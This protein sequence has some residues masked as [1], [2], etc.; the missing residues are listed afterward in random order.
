MVKNYWL[1]LPLPFAIGGIA[2]F[3]VAVLIQRYWELKLEPEITAGNILQA[4]TTILTG[5]I[6]AALIQR[7]IQ[8]DRKEKEILLRHLDSLIE[9]LGQF[10]E[11]NEDGVLT[12]IN[13]SIKRL[14]LACNAAQE[15]IVHLKYPADIVTLAQFEQPIREIR[16]LATDTSIKEIENH[17][18]K[19]RMKATVK[20]GIIQLTEDR[21]AKLDMEVQKLRIQIFKAQVAINKV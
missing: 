10:Q 1:A 6:V 7:I 2:G 12:E 13:A 19:S 11:A 18:N 20:D 8:A 3:I 14:S 21:K 17:V 16:N 9:L 4:S 5:I 15:I